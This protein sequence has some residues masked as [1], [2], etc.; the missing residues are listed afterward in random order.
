[1]NGKT[2]PGFTATAAATFAADSF[3]KRMD[4]R[5]APAD[6]R[7]SVHLSA[8]RSA[9]ALRPAPGASPS[10]VPSLSRATDAAATARICP[11]RFGAAAA[12]APR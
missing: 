1:M 6:E 5:L 10:G 12:P 2:Q 7:I 4:Y 3:R 11:A 9:A 8:L